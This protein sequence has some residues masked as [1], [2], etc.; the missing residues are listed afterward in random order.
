MNQKNEF[1]PSVLKV[2]YFLIP[3]LIIV[4]GAYFFYL[5]FFVQRNIIKTQDDVIIINKNIEAYFIG[6]K[7]RDFNSSFMIYSN[8]LPFDLE[9]KNTQ[10]NNP[11]IKNRFGGQMQFLEAVAT[12]AEQ[13]LYFGLYK[14][15]DKYHKVYTGVSSYIILLTELKKRDCVILSMIDWRRFLPLYLGME[16]G[17]R[18]EQH[19]N[20]GYFNLQNFILAENI[21]QRYKSKDTGITSRKPLSKETAEKACNCHDKNC[22]F[23]IKFL[24]NSN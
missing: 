17:V 11:E 5:K 18:T 13:M 22:T 2:F 14:N 15:Q 7:I 4:F 21:N 6:R 8:L 19:P 20:D 24:H 1:V 23:A 12:S 16:A 9:I 10:S 3:L